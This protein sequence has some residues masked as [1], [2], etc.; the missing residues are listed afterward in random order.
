METKAK[1]KLRSVSMHTKQFRMS[2]NGGGNTAHFPF[3]AI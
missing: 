3:A 2:L 1:H